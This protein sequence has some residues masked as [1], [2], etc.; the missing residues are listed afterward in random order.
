MY[1]GAINNECVLVGV[2]MTLLGV[3]VILLETEVDNVVIHGKAICEMSVIPFEIDS[4]VQISFPV[5]SDVVV[6]FEVISKVVGMAVADIFN[7]KVVNDEAEE[8][9]A[10]FVAPKGGS[11]GAL[12]VSM[13]G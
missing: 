5:F 11:S 13:F 7:T 3:G 2:N 1:F 10:P 4:S 6:L 8:D 9:R 12:V